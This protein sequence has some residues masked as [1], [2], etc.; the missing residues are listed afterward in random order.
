MLDQELELINALAFSETQKPRLNT[1][2]TIVWRHSAGFDESEWA[3]RE[4]RLWKKIR[5]WLGR[6]G[7][8]LRCI[9]VREDGQHKGPH[10]H[11]LL[12]V[13]LV[14]KDQFDA[15]LV[16]SERLGGRGLVRE[17]S[18]TG[19]QHCGFLRY[20]MKTADP[21]ATHYEHGKY[22]NVSETLG[23]RHDVK[24]PLPVSIQRYGVTAN[25]GPKARKAAGFADADTASEA[26]SLLGDIA[27]AGSKAPP[28]VIPL[29]A[30]VKKATTARRRRRTRAATTFMTEFMTHLG[31]DSRRDR[32]SLVA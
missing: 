20:L 19:K 7:V 12:Y 25:L 8:E 32:G 18:S 21:T 22:V 14:L 27:I 30:T 17:K 4:C 2:M 3:A 29:R 5:G 24:T 9:S 15:F 11:A 1:A 23:I 16:E 28:A 31:D 13:P 26:S 10:F 6:H